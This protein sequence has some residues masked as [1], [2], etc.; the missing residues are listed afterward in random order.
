MGEDTPRSGVTPLPAGEISRPMRRCAVAGRFVREP[1]GTFDGAGFTMSGPA[2]DGTKRTKTKEAVRTTA[3]Q[4][5]GWRW[6]QPPAE[7]R[8]HHPC[9]RRPSVDCR[10]H[11][12]PRRAPDSCARIQ[13]RRTARPPTARA[14]PPSNSRMR[15]R[16]S[17]PP[18]VVAGRTVTPPGH[19]HAACQG[20]R[21]SGDS[22]AQRIRRKR[23]RAPRT[24]PVR[25]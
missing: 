15:V 24:S 21:S 12:V 16:L 11:E 14:R 17:R 23:R 3:P 2:Q 18:R 8:I 20:A 25:R 5:R 22:R 6:P 13:P 9:P 4:G 10:R 19:A 7:A 1:S